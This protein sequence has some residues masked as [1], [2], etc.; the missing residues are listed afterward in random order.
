[1]NYADAVRHKINILNKEIK[2]KKMKIREIRS[3]EMHKT[4]TAGSWDHD[5][6]NQNNMQFLEFEA[7]VKLYPS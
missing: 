4:R 3:P 2:T 7:T 1:M 6:L 5:S